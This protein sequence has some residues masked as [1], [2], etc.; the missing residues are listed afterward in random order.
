MPFLLAAEIP[1]AFFDIGNPA[2]YL[3]SGAVSD[4]ISLMSSIR[5]EIEGR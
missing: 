2:H 1:A 5:G 4:I 3:F